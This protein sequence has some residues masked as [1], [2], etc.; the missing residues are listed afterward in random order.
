[1]APVGV[2]FATTRNTAI[3]V[4][5]RLAKVGTRLTG[6]G[7]RIIVTIPLGSFAS[8]SCHQITHSGSLQLRRLISIGFRGVELLGSAHGHSIAATWLILAIIIFTTNLA[9]KVDLELLVPRNIQALI[10]STSHPSGLYSVGLYWISALEAFGSFLSMLAVALD[11]YPSIM[12][13]E[14]TVSTLANR[15]ILE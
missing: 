1:M 2:E 5:E 4:R 8:S 14:E 3:D 13:A 12:L 11:G 6:L 9:L 7:H 10:N 15:S